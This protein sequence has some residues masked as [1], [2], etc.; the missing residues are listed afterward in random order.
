MIWTLLLAV[1]QARDGTAIGI[2]GP[3][4]EEPAQVK[5]TYG[6]AEGMDQARVLEPEVLVPVGYDTG[7]AN[8]W[9][10]YYDEQGRVYRTREVEVILAGS[11]ASSEYLRDAQRTRRRGNTVAIVAAL[12]LPDTLGCCVSEGAATYAYYE[13]QQDF[14]AGLTSYNLRNEVPQV[15]SVAP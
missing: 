9:E 5:P 7:R 11:P 12:L 4:P 14:N 8:F 10:R 2:L 1:A 6:R 15:D 13:A 3:L